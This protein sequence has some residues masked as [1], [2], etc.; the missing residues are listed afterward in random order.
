MTGSYILHLSGSNSIIW[1]KTIIL[2]GMRLRD[3][4]EVN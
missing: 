3:R 1:L 4:G 2:F